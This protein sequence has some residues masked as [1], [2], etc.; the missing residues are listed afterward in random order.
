MD[1]LNPCQNGGTC[2]YDANFTVTCE[3][4]PEW[5][6]DNCEIGKCMI[7][8]LKTSFTSEVNLSQLIHFEITT[9]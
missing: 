4:P 3:C 5:T 8:F 7:T 2:N 9:I 1:Y 6:G